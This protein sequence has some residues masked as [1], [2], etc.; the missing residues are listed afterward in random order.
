MHREPQK[1]VIWARDRKC[2]V[3]TWSFRPGMKF[4]P[5]AEDRDEI[6]P[7]WTNFTPAPCKHQETNNRT[8]RWNSSRDEFTRDEFTRVNRP[9]GDD[10]N[11]A[12]QPDKFRLP[13]TYSWPSAWVI[14][15]GP[16]GNAHER[17]LH[18]GQFLSFE[19][20]Y[21]TGNQTLRQNINQ[22]PLSIALGD[23]IIAP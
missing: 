18:L 16:V 19:K 6:I 5:G 3:F 13:E 21:F 22:R 4:H 9:L 15:A 20:Y 1:N 11:Y 12:T 7:G 23:W 10:F 2:Q 17:R 8:P 14:S